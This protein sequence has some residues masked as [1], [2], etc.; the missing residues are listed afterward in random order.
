M[1]GFTGP[2]LSTKENMASIKVLEI[3]ENRQ[4]RERKVKIFG[5]WLYD[6]KSFRAWFILRRFLIQ[7][8]NTLGLLIDERY[9]I[10]NTPHKYI[11]FETVS[12]GSSTLFIR[13]WLYS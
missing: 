8:G 3:K 6:Q 7:L 11:Y 1:V 4:L 12:M 10:P 13:Q 5:E 9:A 2:G